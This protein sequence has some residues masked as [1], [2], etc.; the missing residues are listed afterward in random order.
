MRGFSDEERERIREELVETGRELLVTYGPE[1]T[2]VADVT[3]PVGI[4]KSTFY[5]FFD[6]KT[7]L[8]LEVFTRESEDF[9]ERVEAKL[10]GVNDPQEG[11][12]RLFRCYAEFA[13]GNLLVQRMI[14]SDNYRELFGDVSPERMAEYQAEGMAAYAPFVERFQ[15]KG[16]GPLEG[17]EPRTV[18][19][20][21]GTIGLL[22]LHEEEYE[23]YGEGYY[24]EVRDALV[25][26][27]ARGLTAGE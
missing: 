27:L 19:G 12:E 2:N 8:Y 15:A 9:Q 3:E 11:L 7:D 14:T 13:E 18:L 26:T 6:S 10:A 17:M 20:V 23:Q 1:K 4:A 25:T 24:E 21:M 22:V 16:S 5:R